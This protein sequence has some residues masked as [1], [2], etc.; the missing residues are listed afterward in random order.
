MFE[1]DFKTMQCLKA[2]CVSPI[3]TLLHNSRSIWH[4]LIAQARVG[5]A[6]I[7]F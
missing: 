2:L 4:L 1:G 3:N 5:F 6:F 7:E